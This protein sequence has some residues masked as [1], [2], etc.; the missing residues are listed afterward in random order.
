MG[1]PTESSPV[2]C[3]FLPATASHGSTS[4]S[5][6]TGPIPNWCSRAGAGSKTWPLAQAAEHA[7]PPYVSGSNR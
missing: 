2:S 7:A 4:T 1:N 5:A 3:M 6:S